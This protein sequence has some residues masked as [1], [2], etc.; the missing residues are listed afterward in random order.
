MVDTSSVNGNLEIVAFL[1]QLEYRPAVQTTL[2]YTINQSER[3]REYIRYAHIN[4]CGASRRL[5]L[6]SVSFKKKKIDWYSRK[7][8]HT[9]NHTSTTLGDVT[10]HRLR[11][12]RVARTA[13]F[14]G[15]SRISFVRS[16][17]TTRA[18]ITILPS[19]NTDG[20]QPRNNAI[21]VVIFTR[22]R[23]FRTGKRAKQTI[24]DRSSESAC[25]SN[26]KSV[27]TRLFCRRLRIYKYNTYLF[28]PFVSLR[29]S[30]KSRRCTPL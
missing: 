18:T 6:K 2:F 9:Y 30:V 12:H 27:C 15:I 11:N 7:N 25:T 1:A 4:V 8:R 23:Q 19:E 13:F 22:H 26:P 16:N 24:W 20:I 14:W 29:F 3:P 5:E 28:I 21:D 10:R 17:A